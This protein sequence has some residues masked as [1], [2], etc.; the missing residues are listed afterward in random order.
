ML[1]WPTT[2]LAAS[3]THYPDERRIESEGRPAGRCTLSGFAMI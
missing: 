3:L 1:G 2:P